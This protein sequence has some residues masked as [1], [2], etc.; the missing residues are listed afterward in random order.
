MKKL[1]F[2][3]AAGLLSVA[4]TPALSQ[5]SP[6]SADFVKAVKEKNGNK[7]TELLQSNPPGIVDAR[8][9][10]GNT[11]LIIAILRQDS[12]WT[13]FLIGKGAD[14]DL[15]GKGGDTPL[16]ASARASFE[17]AVEWLVGAGAKVDATNRA[18]ET[19]LIVAVQQRDLRM[20]RIL[21]SAGADP[22]KTDHAQGFSAREYAERDPRARQILEA[23]NARRPK[24]GGTAH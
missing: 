16:I 19:P 2:V 10:D 14:I 1:R 18:G 24:P 20:A 4:A 9:G 8:D 11:A 3:V 7:V 17:E 12:D 15:P 23:I 21:L 22:D 13:E 6:A 5:I